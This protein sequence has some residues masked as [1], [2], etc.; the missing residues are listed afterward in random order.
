MKISIEQISMHR[1]RL[2]LINLILALVMLF[3][4]DID[5]RGDPLPGYLGYA[6]LVGI[7]LIPVGWGRW[8]YEMEWNE[9]YISYRGFLWVGF[10]IALSFTFLLLY[11][12]TFE[13]SKD[14]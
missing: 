10:Y 7:I 6:L 8:L 9:V 5:L 14:W 11:G 2:S 4:F 3:A 1:K 13:I 12:I